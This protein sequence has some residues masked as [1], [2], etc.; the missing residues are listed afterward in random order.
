MSVRTLPANPSLTQLKKQA[1]TLLKAHRSG[2]ADAVSRLR[3]SMVRLV[4]ATD[5]E[6]ARA[7]FALLDA[8]FVIAR[9]HGFEHWQALAA[10][11]A[12][13][14][15]IPARSDAYFSALRARD[16]DRVR[17]ILAADPELVD[18]RIAD[19]FAP[20]WQP[21][22]PSDRQSNT[23]LHWVAVRGWQAEPL[24][25]L[26]QVLIENGADVDAMGYNG[27]KGVAPAVVL[28]AW[29]GELEVLQLLLEAG[30]DPNRPASAETALYCA[31]EHTALDAPE[32]NKVSVLL[33]H[34]AE[35]D[36]F[37]AAMTGR[38]DLVERLLD[39]YEPLIERRSLKRNRTPLEE[40]V[41]YARWE[42]VERLVAR[43]AT[44]SLHA[45]S[46]MGRTDLVARFLNG[47][48]LHLEATDDSE[49]TPLLVAARHGRAEI[50]DLLLQLGANANTHNRWQ[51]TAL[52]EAVARG[53]AGAVELLLKAGADVTTR[54]RSGKTA[55]EY[56]DPA[57]APLLEVISSYE[58]NGG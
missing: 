36:V 4:D 24:A 52:R 50:V 17:Q 26:A 55:F 13:H 7:R 15:A 56:A 14:I 53:N 25:A 9:E 21:A 37:T 1:K 44:V 12:G 30:A 38:T 18:Q 39:E 57:N 16:V 48:P 35:H 51:I 33:A 22:G 47:D 58:R 19:V 3:V 31:I 43:G 46:A 49:E 34:G 5:A 6:I 29:E 27:N 54:D 40:A 20:T 10:H 8:Q 2:S 23:P 45:A 41:Q 32:P 28:A 11:I 42:T